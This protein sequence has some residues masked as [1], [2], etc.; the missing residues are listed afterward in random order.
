LKEFII[1]PPQQLSSM[2]N[3]SIKY[4]NWNISYQGNK[5]IRGQLFPNTIKFEKNNINLKIFIS[6]WIL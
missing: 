1:N 6:D 4:E 2:N 5:I 3:I